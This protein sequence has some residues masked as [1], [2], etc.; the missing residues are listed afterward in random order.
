MKGDSMDLLHPK[1]REV[2]VRLGYRELLPIQEKAIPVILTRR[3][4]II[5]APTGSGKTEAALFPVLSML[6]EEIDKG[7]D[8]G[9]VRI[10]YITPLRAL[11][12]DVTIRITRLAEELGLKVLLRHGDTTQSDRRR[13]LQDPPHIAVTTPES[14]N[15]L[16]SISQREKVFRYVSWVIVDEVHELLD[17]KRGAELSVVLERLQDLSKKRIQRIGLS[18]TLSRNSLREAAVML[19]YGRFVEIVED[20][21]SKRYSI[22][23]EILEDSKFWE[24]S[25]ERIAKLI[26]GTKGSVLIFTNTRATAEKLA[27]S[28]IKYFNSKK[29]NYRIEVHHGSLA[30][31]IRENAERDFREGRVKAL[32]ATSSMELGIDIGAVDLVIQFMSPR[33]VIAMTQRAGRAGH[34]LGETSRGVIVTSSNI[35]ES[36]ESGI[37]GVRTET[38]HLEDLRFPRNSYDVAA[39]QS[40][41]IVIESRETSVE[42]IH[43]LLTKSGSLASLSREELESILDH[44]D[45]VGV[46]RYDYEANR[47]RMGR[48]TLSYFYRVSMIPDETSFSVYDIATGT[49]VGEVSERFIEANLLKAENTG[50]FRFVL[51]GKVWEAVSIDYEKGKIEAVPLLVEDALVPSW[52][53]EIIPVSYK[54]A[55]E[56]CSIITLCQYDREDCIRAL[57]HR[58]IP[59]EYAERFWSIISETIEKYGK[60]ILHPF[61]AVIE[62]TKGMSILHACLGSNGNLALALLIS[63]LMEKDVRVEFD[64]IPYAIV[65]RAPTTVPGELVERA[66]A[67]AARMDRAERLALLQDAVR[68][69]RTYLIRFNRVAKRMGV[70]DPDKRLP[71]DFTR[72]LAENLRGSVVE[73]ETIREIL[74]EKI[75]LDALNEY[76]DRLREIHVVELDEPS[77]LTREVL[78][79]PY[80]KRDVAVKVTKIAMDKII[81][82]IKKSIGRR[83]VVLVCVSCGRNWRIRASEIEKKPRCPYCGALAIAPLPSTEYGERLLTAYSKL[84][85][86]ERLKGEEKKLAREVKERA[87]IYLNYAGQG[88]G[89]YVVE[90]LM[91]F[92]VGPSRAKRLLADLVS[93]GERAFYQQLLKAMEE[94]AANRQYWDVVKKRIRARSKPH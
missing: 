37:I 29:K 81:E 86:G 78:D 74:Q 9:G 69:S 15:L 1:V 47:A 57:E 70:I 90:A 40:A 18:A 55:R 16:L 75:D 36:L 33:Q 87:M 43:K 85:K 46:I 34:R 35:Y 52:E 92:G 38:G 94:Y 49:K 25:V 41:G 79:N 50:R 6:L 11:N 91:S 32:I 44:L 28:L 3:H 59:V 71:L 66:L 26:D 21:S 14:L 76:L 8:H 51:G 30:R 22:A 13:F 54:V 19:A 67:K 93:R 65:F 84:R 73:I 2:A 23:V 82:S 39:H 89:R 7:E 88:L 60:P 20:R 53:G 72:R 56:V 62:Y 12:R 31:K 27:N 64:Y 5:S 61:N 45:S 48:R 42:R 10:L 63:K 17:S 58:K 68:R 24:G 80:V 77:P 4:V 83:E